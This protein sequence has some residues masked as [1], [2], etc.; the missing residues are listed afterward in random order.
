M[1]FLL[2]LMS[3]LQQNWRTGQNRYCLEAKRVRGKRERAGDRREKCPKQCMHIWI[4]FLKR[5][6]DSSWL[7]SAG[8]INDAI[9]C[10]EFTSCCLHRAVWE[11]VWEWYTEYC[12]PG[13]FIISYTKCTKASSESKIKPCLFPTKKNI[14]FHQ[15]IFF[16]WFLQK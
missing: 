5:D 7:R 3:S 6:W 8:N 13:D 2:L 11:R 14:Y 9:N 15:N 10:L 16:H 1:S 12:R 4:N